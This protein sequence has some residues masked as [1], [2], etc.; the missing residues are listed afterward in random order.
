MDPQESDTARR[1]RFETDVPLPPA[2]EPDPY[3]VTHISM[4]ASVGPYRILGEL[5]RGGMGAVCKAY[6]ADLDRTVALKVLAP[7]LAEHQDAVDRFMSEARAVAQL[8]HPNVVAIYAIG[9]ERGMYFF[10]M[11]LV[12]GRTIQDLIDAH[13]PT[14]PKQAVWLTIQAA[15]GL[16]AACEHGIIHRDVKPANMILGSSGDLKIADFGLAKTIHVEKGLTAAGV[17]VGTPEFL[18]PEQA[19]GRAVDHRADIYSLGGSLVFMLSG[20]SPYEADTGIGMILQHVNG[21]VPQLDHAPPSLNRFIARMMAKDPAARFATY[22]DLLNELLRLEAREVLQDRVIGTGKPAPSLLALVKDAENAAP[23]LVSPIG[24]TPRM[25]HHVLAPVMAPAPVPLPPAVPSPHAPHSPP[26][27]TLPDAPHDTQGDTLNLLARLE[28]HLEGAQFVENKPAPVRTPS[29]E[30]APAEKPPAPAVRAAS[31]SLLDWPTVVIPA[32]LEQQLSRAPSGFSTSSLPDIPVGLWRFSG[33]DR[34]VWI[35][36]MAVCASILTA[37][38][39]GGLNFMAF[40]LVA[41]SALVI[42]FFLF[43]HLLIDAY[44][45]LRIDPIAIWRESQV[46]PNRI[47]WATVATASIRLAPPK[48]LFLARWYNRVEFEFT[49]KDA[50][51]SRIHIPVVF[52]RVCMDDFDQFKTHLTLALTVYGVNMVQERESAQP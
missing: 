3:S 46:A 37:S 49:K 20:R 50:S 40:G 14:S 12:V 2:S 4:P 15:R 16:A 41:L 24:A 28:A 22:R 8:Q 11:E 39:I 51:I 29:P 26:A 43:V 33:P 1:R 48:P 34:W 7:E 19:N 30:S 18:S 17:V 27:P 42:V 5:G 23:A 35:A 21:P 9:Q 47:V 6:Q 10:A 32:K 44:G 52:G 25:S 36:A 38:L 13:G 45:R 31:S